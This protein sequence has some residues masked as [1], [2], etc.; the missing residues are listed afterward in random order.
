M[1]FVRNNLRWGALAL[2]VFASIGLAFFVFGGMHGLYADDY[3]Y[4]YF[5]SDAVKTA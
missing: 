4:R 3:V 2:F 5:G 1:S